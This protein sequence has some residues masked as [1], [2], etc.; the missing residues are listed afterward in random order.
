MHRKYTMAFCGVLF[1]VVVPSCSSSCTPFC[2]C[3]M[4]L[5]LQAARN[6]NVH[7]LTNMQSKTCHCPV[8]VHHRNHVC[9]HQITGGVEPHEGWSTSATL[10]L[11]IDTDSR[12][13]ER[14]R[15]R[16]WQNTWRSPFCTR[17]AIL[18]RGAISCAE[19]LGSL[20]TTPTVLRKRLN[21]S[22]GK[23]HI[24][25][26]PNFLFVFS[27]CPP[28][29]HLPLD[30]D[31]HHLCQP[32]SQRKNQITDDKYYMLQASKFYFLTRNSTNTNY[33]N[34]F[35][36]QEFYP[37]NLNAEQVNV[38]CHVLQQLRPEKWH[39]CPQERTLDTIITSVPCKRRALDDTETK[40]RP[41]Q[42]SRHKRRHASLLVRLIQVAPRTVAATRWIC[43]SP[44]SPEVASVRA[45]HCPH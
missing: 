43:T 8:S 32:T 11:S 45:C 25:I 42:L 24:D 40:A 3:D 30:K 1:S 35:W 41:L 39:V 12:G 9:I 18:Q 17:D 27:V 5:N 20:T 29:V 4:G 36:T 33:R 16:F 2:I 28:A 37:T 6:R 23:M 13:C 22:N 10:V 38:W 44:I 15:G 7:C 31:S 14:V 21:W 19:R 26:A 34:T